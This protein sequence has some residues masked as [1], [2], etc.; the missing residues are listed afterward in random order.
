[1]TLDSD[2]IAALERFV[3]AATGDTPAVAELRRLFPGLTLT[4]CD[5]SDLDTETPF[6][7]GP[8]LSLFLVDGR[9]HCW[10]LTDD[11]SRATGLVITREARP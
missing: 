6:R 4:Q 5:A 9:D 11:P 3:A 2:D 1:M 8:T 7:S 10:V